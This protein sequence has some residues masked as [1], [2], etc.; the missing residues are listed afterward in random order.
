MLNACVWEG[1]R[2]ILLPQVY[3]EKVALPPPFWPTDEE[4]LDK[5]LSKTNWD[6]WF[7]GPGCSI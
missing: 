7:V 6:N 2:E 5:I 3:H 1:K 4:Q